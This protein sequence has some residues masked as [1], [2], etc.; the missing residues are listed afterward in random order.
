MTMRRILGALCVLLAACSRPTS[1]APATFP[2]GTIVDLSHAYDDSTVFWPTAEPFRLEKVSDG[3]T[4]GGYYYAANNF[5]TSEHGGTHIDAPIHFAQGHQ[6]VD[7]IPLD[8]LMGTAA[9]IDVTERA[10]NADYLVTIE[11]IR[12]SEQR[13]GAIPAG[14]IVLIRT[15]YSS[16]WP[17]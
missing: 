11:D 6:T 16:R 2:D 12:Q 13:D 1:N 9:V 10:A 8:R 14:A 15:G 7:R 4:P 17:D 5:A 3:M